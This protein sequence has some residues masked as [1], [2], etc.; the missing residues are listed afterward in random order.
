[1]S[2]TSSTTPID[3]PLAQQLQPVIQA[4]RHKLSANLVALVLFG[5]RARGDQHAESDWD[6]LLV[7]RDLPAKPFQRHLLLKS[8]LP[9]AW[10]SNT[11]I[12]AR[13]PAEFEAHLPDLYLDIALDGIVLCDTDGYMRQRLEH[14]QQLIRARGLRR[15]QQG[16][17]LVWRWETFPGPGWELTWEGGLC[18]R[19]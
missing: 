5:S 13:T 16:R 1:M 18:E 19:E 2:Q 14:L 9:V 11:A 6:L 3:T 8:A 15:D 12:L 10:R 17:E 7:A 4:L